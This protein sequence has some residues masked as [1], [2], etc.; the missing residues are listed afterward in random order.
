MPGGDENKNAGISRD[1]HCSC[2]VESRPNETKDR[3]KGSASRGRKQPTQERQ[4][5]CRE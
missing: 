5:K 3:Y 1:E 4:D 2:V